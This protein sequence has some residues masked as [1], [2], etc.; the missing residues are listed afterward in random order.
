MTEGWQ[1]LSS[2][3]IYRNPWIRLREDDVVRP[4]GSRGIYGIVEMAPA[5]AVVPLTDDGRVHLVGQHRY[6][7]GV[8]SWEIVAGYTDAEEDV[9]E[10]AKRELAEETGLR[11]ARW[12]AL[13]RT[14]LSNSVTDQWG[15][16]YLA[17]GLEQGD[18]SPDETEELAQRVVAFDEAL[19]MARDGEIDHAFSIVALFRAAGHL[20]G[21]AESRPLPHSP[22]EN[23]HA[24]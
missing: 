23:P 5:V 14:Q 2:R 11:A 13:G 1:T 17:E 3:E 7:T 20:G 10:S 18:H 15:H 9:L 19:R 22:P 12:T 8:Y 21:G 24:T 16:V 4:N 6:A